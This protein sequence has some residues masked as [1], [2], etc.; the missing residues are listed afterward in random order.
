LSKFLKI[1]LANNVL[2]KVKETLPQVGL[3]AKEREKNIKGSFLV[4]NDKEIKNKKII[5]VDDVFTTGSTMEEACR[6]LK[7]VGAKQVWGITVARE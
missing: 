4:K 6:A 3:T 1:P 2:I 7:E 5:L